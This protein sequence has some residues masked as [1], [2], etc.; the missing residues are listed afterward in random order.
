MTVSQDSKVSIWDLESETNCLIVHDQIK[1][2][3]NILEIVYLQL[4][5]I[6]CS[7]KLTMWDLWETN[8][9]KLLFCL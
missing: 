8:K 2:L 9:P 1:G 5:C 7:D 4:V 3:V 6:A